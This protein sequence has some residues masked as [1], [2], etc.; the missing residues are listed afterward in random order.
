MAE[1]SDRYPALRTWC[2]RASVDAGGRITAGSA[3]D[4]AAV[5][6]IAANFG[7]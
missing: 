2:G 4:D 1:I 7:R 6:A 5:V 3:D